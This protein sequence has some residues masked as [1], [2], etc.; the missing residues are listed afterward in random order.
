M[1]GPGVHWQTA[2]LYHGYSS[3]LEGRVEYVYPDTLEGKEWSVPY[4][5]RFGRF[6]GHLHRTTCCDCFYGAAHGHS[7][8]GN[9]AIATGA[10]T[11]GEIGGRVPAGWETQ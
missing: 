11:C 4:N 7:D 8:T 10:N 9:D 3:L 5:S 2:L 6:R 1:F